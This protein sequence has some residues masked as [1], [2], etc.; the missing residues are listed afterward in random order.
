MSL[1]QDREDLEHHEREIAAHES[2]NYAI[3]N[4]DE[5][6]LFGCI[7]IDPPTEEM[8]ADVLVSWWVTDDQVGGSLEAELGRFIPRWLTT[9][10]PFQRPCFSP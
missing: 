1:E 3:L 5:S 2:F 8:D 4:A 9:A 6:R 10:W 7:Y